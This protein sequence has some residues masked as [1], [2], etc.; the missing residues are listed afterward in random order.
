MDRRFLLAGA[1]L[2]ALSVAAGAFG[3]HLLQGRLDLDQMTIFEIAVR[4]QMYHALALLAVG[5]WM[6]RDPGRL[7]E[8][9]G[10]LFLAGILLFSGSLYVLVLTGASWLGAVTPLGGTSLLAGWICLAFAAASRPR[11]SAD[12]THATR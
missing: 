3:S 6:E 1:A 12:T 10:W 8:F 5:L 2:A 9:S 7:V 4:Y 11:K